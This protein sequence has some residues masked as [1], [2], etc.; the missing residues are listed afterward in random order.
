[1]KY[2][3]RISI[4]NGWRRDDEVSIGSNYYNIT[5]L[6]DYNWVKWNWF[7]PLSISQCI[8]MTALFLH[9]LK[10]FVQCFG[11]IWNLICQYRSHGNVRPLGNTNIRWWNNSKTDRYFSCYI[12]LYFWSRWFI[13]IKIDQYATISRSIL[14]TF[15]KTHRKITVLESP[16]T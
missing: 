3:R 13:L 2:R 9:Q 11:E 6:P 1:M 8:S 10:L 7:L 5:N 12:F 16:V 4:W 14:K 15:V